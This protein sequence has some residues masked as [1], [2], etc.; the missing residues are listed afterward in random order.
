VKSD[1]EAVL[2]R[3]VLTVLVLCGRTTGENLLGWLLYGASDSDWA[4]QELFNLSRILAALER[5]NVITAKPTRE[6]DMQYKLTREADREW[7][8]EVLQADSTETS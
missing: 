6:G 3:T 7:C 2:R 5:E 4:R 1:P 8:N